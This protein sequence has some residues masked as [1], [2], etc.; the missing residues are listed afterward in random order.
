MSI[1]SKCM[2]DNIDT[3]FGV[4]TI[5]GND[6]SVRKILLILGLIIFFGGI[7]LTAPYSTI[8]FIEN[9]TLFLIIQ[10]L[11][12]ISS[13][14]PFSL[15]CLFFILGGYLAIF[16]Y[17]LAL[18]IYSNNLSDNFF[19]QLGYLIFI[20]LILCLPSIIVLY[21]SRNFSLYNFGRFDYILMNFN[22]SLG[23]IFVVNS[24]VNTHTF[25]PAARLINDYYIFGPI[26]WLIDLGY[27][28]PLIIFFKPKN[29]KIILLISSCIVLDIFSSIIISSSTNNDLVRILQLITLHGLIF[30][31][32]SIGLII[33][34]LFLDKEIIKAANEFLNFNLDTINGLK[35]KYL[36]NLIKNK[37]SYALSRLIYYEKKNHTNSSKLYLNVALNLD[38]ILNFNDYTS[39]LKNIP[40]L[41]SANRTSK[42]DDL[43]NENGELKVINK[44]NISQNFNL[45][46]GL[47]P[48]YQLH[49]FISSG[50]MGLIY[51]VKNIN[52][53]KFYAA[54]LLHPKSFNESKSYERFTLEA[55]SL[56]RLSHTNLVKIHSY[57]VS[58]NNIPYLIM[59][60]VSGENLKD[61]LEVKNILNFDLFFNV[62]IQVC[63][64]LAYINEHGIIH[65]DLKPANILIGK[66]KNSIEIKLV[67]FGIAKVLPQFKTES[68]DLTKS[69]DIVGS[70]LYMSPEQGLGKN[71]DIRSDIYSLGCV[72]YESLTG[73]PPFVGENIMQTIFFHIHKDPKPFDEVRVDVEWPIGLEKIILK[74]L[75]KDMNDRYQ[76]PSL[77][78]ND[79]TKAQANWEF[80]KNNN[81]DT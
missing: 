54:K 48:E 11:S 12:L 35:E 64:A 28:I 8:S 38:I 30:L 69:G 42:V 4:L 47:P 49:K 57:G 26:T 33:R 34:A 39:S 63:D 22:T 16:P 76:Y 53:N 5:A 41:N 70:P 52:D 25:A 46:S 15:S 32:I 24:L 23:Y 27:I 31:L 17:T 77:L 43:V 65:R 44:L 10:A 62:F 20:V 36:Y 60:Y 66:T 56:S 3:S 80:Q 55:K 37:L 40:N 67:D 45:S 19:C 14:I 50:G 2:K 58:Q 6:L 61:Y 1:N 74:C 29:L 75:N 7:F 21:K 68:L 78:K 59:D 81:V 73:K 72:M 79:L 13:T 9:I 51:E 71:V 18:L